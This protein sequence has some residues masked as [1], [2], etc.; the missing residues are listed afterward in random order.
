MGP[1]FQNYENWTYIL[2]KS[3]QMG[4]FSPK[5]PLEMGTGRG[6]QVQI[7]YSIQTKSE[8]PPPRRML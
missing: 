3:I 5:W 2:R 1:F 4:D 8:Y 7:A 6:F